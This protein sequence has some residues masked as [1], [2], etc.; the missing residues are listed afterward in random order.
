MTVLNI[1]GGILGQVPVLICSAQQGGPNLNRV[2]F[3]TMGQGKYSGVCFFPAYPP[4]L[5][6][7]LQDLS[8]L[9]PE[10]V[11]NDKAKETVDVTKE[12]EKNYAQKILK[13]EFK[14]KT[15]PFDHQKETLIYSIYHPRSGLLLDCGL[16]KTK[17]AIDLINYL[18]IPAL[19]VCPATLISN[20]KEEFR[21][22]SFKDFR[23]DELWGT[24]TITKQTKGI[25][26]K[27]VKNQKFE[28]VQ[29]LLASY[30]KLVSN[31]DKLMSE[32]HYGI[33][34][35]DE[36]HKIKGAKSQRT[37]AALQLSQKAH[38]R[39]LMSGTMALGN[40]LDLY[41]QLQ[42]L[43]PQILNQNYFSFQKTYLQFA[44]WNSAVPVGVKNLNKLNAKVRKHTI[45]YLK[46]ECLDLPKRQV[47]NR[48]VYLGKEQNALYEELL[49]GKED[50]FLE[51]GVISREHRI[52]VLNKL[53]QVTGGFLYVG[54]KNL[55]ICNDCHNVL[56]CVEYSIKPYTSNCKVVKK[57]PPVKVKRI[58][59]NPKLDMAM[60]L[61]DQILNGRED[62]KVVIWAKSLEELTMLEESLT[63]EEIWYKRVLED[64]LEDAR[65][66]NE[67]P[68]CRVLI[69][70]IAKGVGFTINAA[71]YVIY[72]SVNFSLE[73][74]K[75]SI[76][77]NYRIGQTRPVTVYHLLAKGTIDERVMEAIKN[78]EDIVEALLN[79]LECIRCKH[80]YICIMK[81][82]KQYDT[83]CKLVKK[84]TTIGRSS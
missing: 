1:S 24:K 39:V 19:V 58:K 11:L 75:Q 42:F 62:N 41:S 49:T 55:D 63:K 48:P 56:N 47:I 38:Y 65:D 74:Y 35:C 23:I 15:T 51:E 79:N 7:V 71:N 33:I 21:I 83:E 80:R 60:E 84:R 69:G 6:P 45:R 8:K 29:V 16:G 37:K 40:P 67:D 82:V 66:F 72:Y 50:L 26:T 54:Q 10:Y 57:A 59:E 5:K 44:E 77:R 70:N 61:V 12:W 32:Y 81:G 34:I 31:L 22:H 28:G 68:K 53:H 25:K 18:D 27:I 14:F 76:D 9:F 64:P 13:P 20:W 4:F 3:S 17:V 46:E 73:N 52:V 78:K 43:S 30:D 2:S 36:S